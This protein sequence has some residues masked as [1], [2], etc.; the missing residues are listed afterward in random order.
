[1]SLLPT[2]SV[3][4]GDPGGVGPEVLVRALADKSRRKSGRFLIHGSAQVMHH[5]AQ[6]CGV[7]PFWWQVDARSPLVSTIDSKSVVLLDSDPQMNDEGVDLSMAPKADG[8]SGAMSYHWVMEAI[9]DTQ[10]DP[11]D[12]LRAQGIVTG[13]INKLA[14]SMAGKNYPGH[15][16]LIAKTLGE[17]RFAMMFV[18]DKLRVVLAT[19]HIALNDI[20]DVLTIG[21]VHTAIDLGHQACL[22]LGI[23][24]PR[25]AVCGLNPHA[26]E[27]GLM[28]DEEQ[29]LIKP[30]MDLARGTGMI[31]EGP[32]PADTIYRPAMEGKYDL[33]V[34]MYHDQG[35]IPVKL[36]ERDMAVNVTLG[37]GDVVRTSPDHGTA[38]DIAGKGIADPGSTAHAIDLA[39]KLSS[40]KTMERVS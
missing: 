32:F 29:R 35:L 39:L 9:R 34:A 38:F 20:R 36:L 12:P 16:E 10:R 5:A 11:S 31:V 27:D 33:V 19:V 13:P 37:L 3:S 23:K 14:W 30:A 22:D 21:K 1:M 25:M 17:R 40:A 4:M 2:I 7:E 15:T 18:G 24:R 6:V 26:G 28:G 8:V